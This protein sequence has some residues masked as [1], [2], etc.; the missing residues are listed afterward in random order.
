MM[1]VVVIGGIAAGMSTASKLKRNLRDEV[2]IVVYE[3]G[4]AISY[5]ACGIPF[6][7]SDRIKDAEQL[8]AKRPEEFAKNGID[9]KV[10]HE[11]TSVD[12]NAKT[13]AVVNLKTGEKFTRSYD[14]L[15]IGSGARVKKFPPFDQEKANL[16][17]IRDVDDGTNVKNEL[18]KE[19]IKNIVVVGAGFIGLEIVDA[20]RHYGKKVTLIELADRILS[21]MDP[22]IT[23]LLTAELEKHEVC[24]KTGCKVS[25]L[26]CDGDKITQ[27]AIDTP[28][29]TESVDADMV[30]NC[31]GIAPNTEFVDG[32]EKASN[33][34]IIVN[35]RMETS[36]GD[37]YAA[38]DCSIMKSAVSGEL[39]YAPLGTNAN[40]QGR[41]IADILG[42]KEPKPFKLIGSTAIKLFGL[43]AAK[44]GISEL[45][46]QKL[47][48]NYKANMITGNSY[49]SYYG[50]EKVSIKVV[51]DAKTR[52]ILGAQT[53]GQGI[54]VPRANYY[55]VAI[56]AGLTV[57]EFGFMDLC[58]S[59]P[60]SGVWDA[61]LIA[62]NTAK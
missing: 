31:A 25:Q 50:T 21:A 44:V 1:N 57:D 8:V 52:K 7:V 45:D 49:A 35:E 26:I 59:P 38:G 42:G 39:M 32:I 14:K 11:V 13:V 43:D 61:S 6:Y 30:I 9:V 12:T 10:Y 28:D 33:G 16:Y 18:H 24:V 5:G 48:L 3:K 58:Y 56:Y 22:E 4:G 17:Q 27:V 34:A 23:E 54:V 19:E 53:V 46:A 55:A 2:D 51:Y 29:G 41:I 62:S 20:C 60:F 15:I 40:K 37:V 36:A 47:G